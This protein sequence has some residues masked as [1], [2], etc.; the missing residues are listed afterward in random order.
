M[1]EI[2]KSIIGICGRENAGKSTIA[3]FLVKPFDFTQNELIFRSS[4]LYILSILFGWDYN[5]LLTNDFENIA[6]DP[7]WNMTVNQ[8]LDLI[9]ELLHDHIDEKLD[10]FKEIKVNMHVLESKLNIEYSFADPLKKIA[11]VIFEFYGVYQ[12]DVFEI[13]KGNTKENRIKREE[14]KTIKY[15]KCGVLTG[16]TCLEYLGTDVFRNHFDNEIWIKIFKRETSKIQGIIVIADVRFENE[17]KAIEEMN[18]RFIS[19]YRDEK[20][21]E[22]TD[23]DR[24]KHESKWKF[25]EFLPKIKNLTRIHNN[26]TLEDLQSKLFNIN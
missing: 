23:E 19:V 12:R 6:R 2:K 4:W 10:I 24:K 22:I 15:E 11:S 20:D 17:W 8:A 21:L 9:I 5:E 18:G 1:S 7:I 16:R 26:G 14:M 13:L 3:N 25:L